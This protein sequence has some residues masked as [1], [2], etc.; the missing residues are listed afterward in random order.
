[1]LEASKPVQV[2]HVGLRWLLTC[3]HWQNSLKFLVGDYNAKYCINHI[4]HHR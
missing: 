1:M 2:N 3:R 4:V